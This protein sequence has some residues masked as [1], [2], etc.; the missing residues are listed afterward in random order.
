MLRTVQLGVSDGDAAVAGTHRPKIT[1]DSI[2]NQ[3]GFCDDKGDESPA[4]Y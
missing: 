3:F 2:W 4:S 1:D